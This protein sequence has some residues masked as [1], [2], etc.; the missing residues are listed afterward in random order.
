MLLAAKSKS[1]NHC[2]GDWKREDIWP[3]KGA[4][5][6]AFSTDQKAGGRRELGT[7]SIMTKRN[8]QQYFFREKKTSEFSVN[9]DHP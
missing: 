6:V 3:E 8:V 4:Q 9:L 1:C 2:V 5:F 7:P